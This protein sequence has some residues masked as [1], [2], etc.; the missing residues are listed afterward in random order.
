MPALMQVL[1]TL[2]HHGPQLSSQKEESREEK[3]DLKKWK[4]IVKEQEILEFTLFEDLEEDVT[5]SA[6]C[7]SSPEWV[8]GMRRVCIDRDGVTRHVDCL[9]S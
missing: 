3:K 2:S 7:R 8:E 9:S 6:T 5:I 1:G 4:S